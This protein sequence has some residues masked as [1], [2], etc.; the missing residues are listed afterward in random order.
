MSEKVFKTYHQQLDI[1]SSRGMK[2]SSS[3]ERRKAKQ[4]IQREGYYKLINGYKELFILKETS[5]D[6]YI[7]G[8]TVGEIFA[9]YTF[10]RE[11]REIFLRY[12][13][14]VETNIKS[15]ISYRISE[16]YGHD[17]FLKYNNF[18]K[19]MKDADKQISSVLADIQRQISSNTSDPCIKHYLQ[20]YSYIPMW[21]LNNILTLGAISKFY[22][23]MKVQD[24][25]SISRVFKVLD[26]SLES[27]VN[28]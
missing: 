21:V 18:N 24:R 26:N 3:S 15:L 5:D 11:L 16:N 23:I 13:L 25:Q 10:D 1:L 8:T 14:H 4:I 22:S 6:Q 19:S 9:L 27:F 7:P 20:N 12:I 28:C 2:L 17:N